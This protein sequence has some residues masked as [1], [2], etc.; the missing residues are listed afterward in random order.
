M[1]PHENEDGPTP[2][3]LDRVERL[4]LLTVD[5]GTERRLLKEKMRLADRDL[6]EQRDELA[7]VNRQLIEIEVKRRHLTDRYVE[8]EERTGRLARLYVTS[9]RLHASRDWHEALEAIQ[10]VVRNLVGSEET[11]VF[12]LTPDGSALSL[13]ASSGIDA[14]AY[15]RVPLGSGPIGEVGRSGQPYYCD[16]AW[17]GSGATNRSDLT[18][19]VPLV[20]DAHTVGA[21]A[22]FRLLPQKAELD[23]LDRELLELVARHA[24]AALGR[25]E[26]PETAAR[27]CGA[28]PSPPAEAE[29]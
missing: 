8:A 29:S 17:S 13:V 10:E 18:A 25:A 20:R 5:L 26:P 6:R 24:A 16:A 14:A 28:S 12:E 11:A 22:V 15:E 1:R 19:C 21:V 2:D 7:Q 9:C 3:L 23:T 4:G 27:G